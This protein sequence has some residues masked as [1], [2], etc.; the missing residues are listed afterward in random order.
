MIDRRTPPP[1]RHAFSMIELV[2]VMII[3]STIAV[4]A[5]PRYARSTEH[6]RANAVSQRL[7]ADLEVAR[8]HARA[9]GTDVTVLF[10]A[11]KEMYSIPKLPSVSN[12]GAGTIVTLS[13]APYRSNVAAASFAGATTVVFDG[14]GLP[15]DG[16]WIAL[17][18][19]S[20]V[21]CVLVDGATGSVSVADHAWKIPQDDPIRDNPPP[22]LPGS[23]LAPPSDPE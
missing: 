13:L 22:D 19:G 1:P 2:V 16:G 8:S 17:T 7:V 9:T 20:M 15:S 14:Y 5:I 21:K 3:I 18:S 10:D 23:L 6:Y 12:P 11:G 4:I